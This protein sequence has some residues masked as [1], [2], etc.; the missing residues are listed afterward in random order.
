MTDHNARRQA[1]DDIR[2]I[3]A[4]AP[5]RRFVWRLIDGAGTFRAAFAGDA[6]TTAYNEG[7]R[8]V[9]IALMLEAQR[10]ASAEYV[11]M[12]TEQAQAAHVAGLLRSQGQTD[13]E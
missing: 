1:A 10:V 13:G 11:L 9:G 5:G 4:S 2:N 12:L 7:R 3:M 6:W 8:A